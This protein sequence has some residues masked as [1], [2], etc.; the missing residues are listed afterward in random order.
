MSAG[1]VELGEATIVYTI[2]L[3]DIVAK[4]LEHTADDT[5]TARVDNNTNLPVVAT[6]NKT[7]LIGI[8]W[9]VLKF[10]A[11]NELLQVVLRDI[12]VGENV[13]NLANLI[14]G[15]HELLC[16]V[17]IIG[18]QK[19]TRGVAVETTDRVDA[20]LA[21]ASDN[22]HNSAASLRVISGRHC[23]LRLVEEDI[24]LLLGLD[25]TAFIL[26][27]SIARDRDT[28]LG[29]NLAIDLNLTC[30][31]EVVSLAA[32]GDACHG[33]KA[34]EPEHLRHLLHFG[35]CAIDLFL[36]LIVKET[37][38]YVVT[39]SA[40]DILGHLP[41]LPW[42]T[43]ALPKWLATTI[44]VARAERTALAITTIVIAGAERTTLALLVIVVAGAERTTLTLLVIVVAGAERTTLTLLVIVVAGAERATLALLVIIVVT[45]AE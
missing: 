24:D 6:I 20:L 35:I 16:H 43:G 37:T 33:N 1:N 29:Y 8:D 7:Y 9:S 32:A 21:C 36:Y 19:H 25:D 2:Q 31:D 28:H 27:D 44:V 10:K 13:V 5:V 14:F 17:T 26:D 15:V 42:C 23:I 30:L 38:I 12:L 18:E 22:I 4:V 45:G 40:L 39:M 41:L 11:L 34:I 3:L